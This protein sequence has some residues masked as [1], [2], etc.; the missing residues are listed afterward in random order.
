MSCLQ[1]QIAL[2]ASV[3]ATETHTQTH[4]QN[5]SMRY[6][7]F[8]LH[9]FFQSHSSVRFTLPATPAQVES[10]DPHKQHG[11]SVTFMRQP[12]A[13]ARHIKYVIVVEEASRLSSHCCPCMIFSSPC[14]R[15]GGPQVATCYRSALLAFLLGSNTFGYQPLG[16]LTSSNF[17]RTMSCSGCMS[18][19]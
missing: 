4:V 2:L 11:G 5:L 16:R 13:Q 19:G 6:S 7:M 9:A 8:C 12:P 1:E 10:S 18:V 14:H 15:L 3:K 17:L